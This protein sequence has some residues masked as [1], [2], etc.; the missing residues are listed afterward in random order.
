M[1]EKYTKH[2][3]FKNSKLKSSFTNYQKLIKKKDEQIVTIVIIDSVR[4]FMSSDNNETNPYLTPLKSRELQ[5]PKC[6]QNTEK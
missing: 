3:I 2:I 1:W 4:E 6:K 5:R